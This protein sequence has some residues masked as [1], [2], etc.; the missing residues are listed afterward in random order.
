MIIENKY[1][2][3]LNLIKYRYAETNYAVWRI[4]NILK[5]LIKSIIGEIKTVNS[6]LVE[7]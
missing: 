2:K 5:H 1:K 3:T 4:Y 7:R 6:F